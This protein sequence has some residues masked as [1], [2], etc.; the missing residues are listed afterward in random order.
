M[1]IAR[2]NL[3]RYWSKSPHVTPCPEGYITLGGVPFPNITRLTAAERSLLRPVLQRHPE[4]LA[5]ISCN[6]MVQ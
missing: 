3:I 2:E 4:Y 6:R 5:E 1:V